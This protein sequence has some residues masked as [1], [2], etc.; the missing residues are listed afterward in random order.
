LRQRSPD[1]SVDE[2]GWWKQLPLRGLIKLGGGARASVYYRG[3]RDS[4]RILGGAVKW[5]DDSRYLSSGSA[6]RYTFVTIIWVKN[7]KPTGMIC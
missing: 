7:G 4:P 2:G 6:V 3:K 5:F 1:N